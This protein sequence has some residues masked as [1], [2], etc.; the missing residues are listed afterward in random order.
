MS[1]KTCFIIFIVAMIAILASYICRFT[2]ITKEV[3]AIFTQMQNIYIVLTA[4][5]LALLLR[6]VKY[7]WL[8]MLGLAI[9]TAI[10]VHTFILGASVTVFAVL[11]KALAFIVYVYLVCLLRFML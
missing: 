4:I 11:Y 1:K 8:I 10:V 9:I 3:N 7:Y 6:K 5:T 2:P